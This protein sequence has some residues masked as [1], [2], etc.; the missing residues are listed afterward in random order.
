MWP[1]L[2]SRSISLSTCP[3]VGRRTS[4]TL[5]LLPAEFIPTSEDDEE[6]QDGE[7]DDGISRHHQAAGAPPDG[8]ISGQD[9]GEPEGRHHDARC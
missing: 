5:P 3:P 1:S 2:C 9:N 8:V 4:H 6:A 7:E